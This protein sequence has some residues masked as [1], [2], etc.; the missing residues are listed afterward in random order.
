[1]III[2]G[3]KNQGKTTQLKR[4]ID[5]LKSNN[6]TVAGFYSEKIRKDNKVMGYDLLT[7]TQNEQFPFLSI[8]T[9]KEQEKIGKFSINKV[10]FEIGNS[11]IKKAI[12]AKVDYIVIDEV[13][14]LE[15]DNKGWYDSINKLYLNFTNEIIFC[16]RTE[17]VQS[18]IDKFNFNKVILITALEKDISSILKK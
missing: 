14:K 4:I 2:H 15:L 9:S 12:L 1:M 5:I 18:I 13:G 6:K 10:A 11:E 7:I 17:F 3:D 16:V 8:N